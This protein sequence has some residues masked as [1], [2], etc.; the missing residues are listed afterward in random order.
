LLG[1]FLILIADFTIFFV[2]KASPLLKLS[3]LNKIP[4]EAWIP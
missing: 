3:W 1:F 4:L 2:I